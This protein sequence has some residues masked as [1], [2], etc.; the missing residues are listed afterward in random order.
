MNDMFEQQQNTGKSA[1][2][3]KKYANA[4]AQ[5]SDSNGRAA[6]VEHELQVE[7]VT[8][9]GLIDDEVARRAAAA[10]ERIRLEVKAELE[11]RIR[12]EVK[13]ELEERIRLEV[14]TG[15]EE[16]RKAMDAREQGLDSREAEVVKAAET[17]AQDIESRVNKSIAELR[18]RAEK[19]ALTRLADMFETFLQ[20]C[21]AVMDKDSSKGQELLAQYRQVA[22]ETQS[23]L[24]DEIKEKLDKA[25]TK[26]KAKTD[27]VASLVRMLFTQKRERVV[28]SPEQRENLY[29][30]AMKSWDLPPETKAEFERCREYCRDYRKKQE[31]LKLLK[32]EGKKKGND[33][34]LFW[35]CHA[36]AEL[37]AKMENAKYVLHQ[38]FNRQIKK[39]AQDGFPMA[40]ATMDDWHQA[41]CGMIEPLYELQKKRVFSSMLLAGDGSPF[42]IINSEK[43]KTVGHYLIQY[44]SVTTGIPVFLVNTHNKCGRGKA[45]IMDNLKDWTGNVFMCDAYAGYDWMKKIDGLVLC[46]CV[47]HARRMAERS[48]RENPQL[49]QT[50]L[51]FYQDPYL[52]EEIIKEKGLTGEEKAR[53]RQEHAGPIWET[54]RAWAANTILDVPKDSLIFRALNYLLRNY[55][56]LT[57][58]LSIPEMPID[59]TDTERLIR[60]MVMGKKSYLF[61]RDL[62]AC[63]RAAMMYSL[64]GACKVLGKN[65]ERWLSYVLKNIKTTP[66]DK[67]YTLLPEFWEDEG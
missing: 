8:R 1:S 12:L 2:L 4:V 42:P 49:S 59:N 54:F 17:I 65:P 16:R 45:D 41:A 25:E 55:D 6:R 58:Y 33:E 35:K 47:A 32:G 5:L 48:L 26:N 27:Q 44:R 64:F 50:A 31:T 15:F 34:S 37:V 14:E 10:E 11:E 18:A 20:A 62:D 67:L 19:T 23:L 3:A 21:V 36:T 51:L 63:R 53:F 66:K 60:D 38:P 61:C 57:H 13:A 39:M 56:E 46:R 22:E 40:A 7:R 9:Q 30:R 52:V 43:H 28:F 24:K 29:D